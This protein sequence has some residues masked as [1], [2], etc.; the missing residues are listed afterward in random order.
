MELPAMPIALS[1]D[2]VRQLIQ[3][4]PVKLPARQ[5]RIYRE[6]LNTIIHAFISARGNEIAEHPK[7]L[8]VSLRDL[9]RDLASIERRLQRSPGKQ[10]PGFASCI[11]TA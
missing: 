8:R 10:C 7:E 4:L 9:H 6:R 3:C 1:E 2:D 5:I 11:G